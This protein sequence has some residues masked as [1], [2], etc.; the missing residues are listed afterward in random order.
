MDGSDE[1]CNVLFG[2]HVDSQF[3][4]GFLVADNGDYSRGVSFYSDNQT[5]LEVYRHW[6]RTDNLDPLAP[7]QSL[8][9]FSGP[10]SLFFSPFLHDENSF[11]TVIYCLELEC[12]VFILCT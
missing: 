11:S 7:V 10:L 1:L 2:L 5:E 9:S 12:G 8:N 6:H 3:V 4:T